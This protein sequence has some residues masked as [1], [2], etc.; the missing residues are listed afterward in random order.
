[1]EFKLSTTQIARWVIGLSWIYHGLFPKL[2]HIAPIELHLASQVG[3]S[4]DLTILL[5]KFA[6]ISDL[7]FGLIFLV[8]YKIRTIIYLN[9]T[10]LT[11]LL[12][13]VMLLDISYLFEAFNPVTTNIPLIALSF[14]LLNEL[15]KKPKEQS[16]QTDLS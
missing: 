13:M 1:M 14:V 10:G 7:I 4:P 16:T 15:R 8:L 6:G 11:L 12:L 5:I 9:I 3:L 2:I